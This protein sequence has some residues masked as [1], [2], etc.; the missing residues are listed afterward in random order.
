M[1]AL[2]AII[3]DFAVTNTYTAME[4]AGAAELVV[5]NLA[6]MRLSTLD[7]LCET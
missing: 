5:P 3:F 7:A 2:Q 6:A 1:R 4:L